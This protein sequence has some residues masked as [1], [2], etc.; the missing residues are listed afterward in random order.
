MKA[1]V[2]RDI[3]TAAITDLPLPAINEHQ[4]LVRNHFCAVCNATDTKMYNGK[5]ATVRYPS[6]IGHEGSGIVAAVGSAVTAVQP[7]DRVLGAGYPASEQIGSF[8]GQYAEYGVTDEGSIIRIPDEVTLEQATL[9]HMLGEALNALEI[10]GAKIG[11]NLLIIGCGAV[12]LSILTVALH[13][14]ADHIIMVDIADDKLAKAKALGASQIINS[15]R[16]NVPERVREL[17]GDRG[18]QVVFEA[19]GHPSTYQLAYDLVNENGTIIPFGL[20]EGTLEIPFRRLYAKQIQIRWCR[21][22]GNHGQLYKKIILDML[23]RGLINPAPLITGIRDLSD[24]AETIREIQAGKH[25]RTLI[26]I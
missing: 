25:I 10:S 4:V 7:G 6:V 14:Y 24:F 23:A 1:L 21:S 17:T 13:S 19:V 18:V 3:Q 26:R 22:A 12:G 15:S 8:W 9:S 2:L 11:D 16:E 5:H 20:I